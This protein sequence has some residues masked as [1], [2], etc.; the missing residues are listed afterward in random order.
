MATR[1]VG[2]PQGFWFTSDTLLI[3]AGDEVSAFYGRLADGVAIT[4]DRMAMVFRIHGNARWRDG[5][6]ITAKDVAYTLDMRRNQPEGRMYFSFIADVG[7]LDD[8]HVIV[9]LNAP[10]T[11]NHIIMIQFT[12]ILPEHYWRD[13][14][15]EAST[16]TPPLTSGPYKIAAIKQGRFIEYELDPEY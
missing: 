9:R 14:D 8:R 5:V 16:L 12:S 1:G 15:P 7:E 4:D 2:A 3:R 10:I 11:L 13:R 6:P